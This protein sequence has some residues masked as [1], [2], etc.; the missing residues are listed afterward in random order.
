MIY[1]IFLSAFN[2]YGY[3]GFRTVR[4]RGGKNHA[5]EKYCTKMDINLE[6]AYFDIHAIKL[7]HSLKHKTE[8]IIEEL[9]TKTIYINGRNI[10]VSF[11]E[12]LADLMERITC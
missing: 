5:F 8:A 6:G 3:C 12:D 1:L 9:E 11:E 7:D 2:E 4:T 10:K